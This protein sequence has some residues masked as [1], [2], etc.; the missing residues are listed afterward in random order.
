M[1][2]R[3]A[4]LAVRFGC[5]LRG[6]PDTVIDRVAPLQD[7]GPGAL[8]F[9]ANPQYRRHLQTTRASAV[10]LDASTAAECPVAALVARNPYATYAR[11]AQFLYPAPAV[12]G[13]RHPSAVDIKGSDRMCGA[14]V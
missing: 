8:S 11:V 7:A 9:L 1:P 13:G 4:D 5:E 14:G 2:A 3:L 10:V 6:D 12:T